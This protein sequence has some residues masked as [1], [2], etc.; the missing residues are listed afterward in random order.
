MPIAPLF[1][2]AD[3]QRRF[4]DALTRG[5]LPASLLIQGPR[6]VGKQRLALWLAQLLLCSNRTAGPCGACRDCRFVLELTHPDLH[7]YFPRPRLKDADPDLDDVREDYDEAVRARAD[8][9]GLYEPPS[10]MEGIYVA[11][12]R[13]IVQQAAM[14]PA[15]GAGKVFIIGDAERMASQEG[16]EQAA[17]AFLKLLEEPPANT[18]I[19]LTSSEPGAL[20]PTVR[21][22]VVAF[23]VGALDDTRMRE[24]MGHDLVATRLKKV[25]ALPGAAD[26][27]AF[28]AGAPGRLLSA[29]SWSIAL[30][31][32][33]RM[34]DAATGKRAARYEAAWG[35]ASSKARGAF[36]DTLDALT[37][38]LHRRA[39]DATRAGSDRAAV[40]ASRAM[41]RVELAKER[42][43][44]N[45]SPQ[46]I[47]VNLIR[48]LQEILT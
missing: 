41:E 5:T 8:A 42:V 17:N 7:W 29:E 20:L 46:L 16:S 47:T 6:G 15:L 37:E 30:E 44:Q 14:S 19:V 40:A 23:S 34:L 43:T 9:A 45:V 25:R 27:L 39:R 11:T 38:Q 13:A 35:T 1:G 31:S 3:A 24:F 36:A 21:S 18:T 48:E 22:R 28:A 2:H 32:A 10:G 26:R 33:Q 4:Q 12:V